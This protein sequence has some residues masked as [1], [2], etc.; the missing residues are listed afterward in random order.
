VA[1]RLPALARV[2]LR[3]TDASVREFVAGDLEETFAAIAASDGAAR[4]RRWSYREALALVLQHPWKPGRGTRVKGDGIMRTFLQDLFY[5]VRMV[6]RQPGFSLVVVMTL[7]LAIGANT[8]IFSFAN[9]LLL[10]PLPLKDTDTLAWIFAV[11]PHMGGNRRPLSIPEFMDYRKSLTSFEALGASCR[12]NATLTGRGDARRIAAT[13]VSANLIDLWGVRLEMGR[14]FSP[15]ADTPG[16]AGEV[17]IS[18]HYWQHD[19]NGD[20]A[21]VGQ[22]MTLDGKPAT[23]MGVL[24]P[25]IEIGNLSEI[26][27]WMPL[28]L[29]ADGPREERILRVN[30]R[31]TPGVTIAQA[32]A[33]VQKVAQAL[34]REHPKTNEGWGVRVA[35]TREAMTGNDTFVVMA[36]LS[37]VV[38]LVLLLACANL[39][40]LVLSRVTGRRREL[41]VRSALGAS[42]MRV[43]RQMLTENLVYGICGG[44]VGLG[45]AYLGLALIRAAAYEPFFAMVRIDRNVLVFTAAL[46]LLT[47][48]LFAIL[49]ALQ[50]TRADAGDA[51][52]DGGTRTAG[53]VRAARSRSVLIVAQLGLAVMLLVL[54]TLLVKAMVY[55][56][57]A[58]LGIDARRLLTARIDLPAWRYTNTPATAAYYDQL[59]ARLHAY[60]GIEGAALTNRILFL[61]GEPITDVAIDGRASDRPEDRPW[62]VTST[63]SETYFSTVGIPIVA[64]RAFAIDDQPG[65]TP[66]AI[67]NREMARRYL[68]SAERAIGARLTLAGE[69]GGSGSLQIVGVVGDVLRADREGTNP[70]VYVSLRQRPATS[71]ALMVR[72]SDPSVAGATVRAQIRALDA[73]VPVYQMRPMQEALDDDMSSSRVLGSLFVAFALLALVLA[74]SGLY[75]VVSYS[76]SQRVKEFGVRIALG[77]SPGD[78]TRMMLRQTGVLVAIGL[79]IG[80]AGGRVLAMTAMTLLYGVSPSDPATYAGVAVTLGTIA[81]LASY[82]PVRRATA[83][84]P[85]RALRLE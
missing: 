51:L 23:V 69:A 28:S 4:A 6:R 74:A 47:P 70:Q 80:L 56:E 84:D 7:A 37:T 9:I 15:G 13:R 58:P 27:V 10:R 66:V 61:D 63:V 21:I 48:M 78:I 26:D 34:A 57:E 52:K 40:N 29:S 65:R 82:V 16:A 71:M 73:D 83:V 32:G 20:R 2:L 50:S 22:T 55:I 77:A 72:A 75:A 54:G 67:V 24:S 68:G 60:P 81:L 44:I 14:G 79:A 59:L 35:P 12:T 85:V 45:V 76:A 39:A 31:L 53:G 25:E 1:T 17:V 42:R 19:L 36:L 43:I 8:V 33:E 11:D 5:G 30:G 64:G 46:A 62:A 38:G 18:H 41:A 49:P 3:L